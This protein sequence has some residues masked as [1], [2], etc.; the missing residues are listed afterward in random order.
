MFLFA[1]FFHSNVKK[2]FGFLIKE[3]SPVEGLRVKLVDIMV[4]ELMLMSSSWAFD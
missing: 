2:E 1:T 4:G 3:L